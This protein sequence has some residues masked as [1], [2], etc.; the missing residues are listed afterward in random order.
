MS[1]MFGST[2]ICWR[3]LMGV[4]QQAEERSGFKMMTHSVD[5]QRVFDR[6]RQRLAKAGWRAVNLKTMLRAENA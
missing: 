2:M 3:S 6:R 1:A 5:D 4:A